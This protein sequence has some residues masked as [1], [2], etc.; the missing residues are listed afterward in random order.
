M[1][2][3]IHIILTVV[4]TAAAAG[5]TAIEEPAAP[6]TVLGDKASG[7]YGEDEI[8]VLHQAEVSSPF[9]FLI[10]ADGFTHEDM[11]VG[12]RFEKLARMACE[13]IFSEE[14]LRRMR[15]R[16]EVRM[17]CTPCSQ[18]GASLYKVNVAE[19]VIDTYG[20]QVQAIKYTP[21]EAYRKNSV[22]TL[23]LHN[24]YV[25]DGYAFLPSDNN[26]RAVAC[27]AVDMNNLDADYLRKDIL[28]ELVGHCTGGLCDEYD[29]LQDIANLDT[30]I[31]IHQNSGFFRNISISKENTSWNKYIGRQGYEDIGYFEGAAY[32]KSGVYR[33]TKNS[34]MRAYSTS[35]FNAISRECIHRRIITANGEKWTWEQFL[36]FD[37]DYVLGNE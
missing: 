15:E 3:F 5:C 4:L 29:L 7:Y 21:A 28:H 8:V 19:A 11:A 35:S 23:V 31:E 2:R 30:D 1:R 12:G 13:D 24:S 10:L 27:C 20:V 33:S 17:V 16:C 36:E 26:R 34:I 18:Y 14:P 37:R 6:V 9:Y 22:S 32:R 25:N